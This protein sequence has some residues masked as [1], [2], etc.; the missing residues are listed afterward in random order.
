MFPVGRS[1]ISKFAVRAFKSF[2]LFAAPTL[3]LYLELLL[4]RERNLTVQKIVGGG[5]G[6]FW[7]F[8]T[9]LRGAKKMPRV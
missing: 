2:Q 5:V 1:L 7:C 4:Y 9:Q 3:L 8:C 6:P